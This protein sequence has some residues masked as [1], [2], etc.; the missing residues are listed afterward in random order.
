MTLVAPDQAPPQLAMEG[1]MSQTPLVVRFTGEALRTVDGLAEALFGDSQESV[2][3]LTALYRPVCAALAA[4]IKDGGKNDH[5]HH[6]GENDHG[7][8]EFDG[9]AADTKIAADDGI[10]DPD[11]SMITITDVD[12]PAVGLTIV[13]ARKPDY[14]VHSVIWTPPLN[15]RA[16][17]V[18]NAHGLDVT[19]LPEPP[20]AASRS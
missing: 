8:H 18:S 16:W 10:D 7:H 3:R 19:E 12:G 1:K 15:T 11:R 6:D 17:E 13:F 20:E 4:Y 9:C 2:Q 5:G 14:P